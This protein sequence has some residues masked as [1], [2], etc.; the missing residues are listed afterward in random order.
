MNKPT[1]TQEVVLPSKGLLNPEIPGG[2]VTQRCM[3]VY[4]QKYLSGSAAAD[5]G[6]RRLI[7]ETTV[8]P[9]TLDVGKLT[10]SDTLFL[11]FKLRSLSYGEHFKY[12][13][14]CPR[15]GR[16]F[17]ADVEISK[18]EVT[19]LDPDYEK[20]LYIELPVRGDKVHTRILLNRDLD[21]INEEL[22][23]LRSR[24]ADTEG[25]D[26]ILRISRMIT[27]ID[28]KEPNADDETYLDNPDDIRKYVQD[29]T[30]YDA[31]AI[32]ST[33]ENIT[34]GIHDTVE[35]KCTH[36]NREVTV[37]LVLNPNFFR[38][39]YDVRHKGSNR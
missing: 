16:D 33:V 11:L 22:D 8:S 29:M 6:L 32:L 28:L 1:L 36:C 38:P 13:I 24:G 23:R 21:Y 2:K 12:N 4:D 27:R 37:P 31:T 18:I 34:F 30:D 25:L 26:Y 10:V 3:M 17:T 9:E 35:T 7:K 19:D 5:N 15:C 20:E 39:K 14:Q